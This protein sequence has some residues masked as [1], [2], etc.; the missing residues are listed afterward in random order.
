MDERS[1]I[2]PSYFPPRVCAV[3]PGWS[4]Q[5]MVHV[6]A[7][8]AVRVRRVA[9]LLRCRA[10][11]PLRLDDIVGVCV[12]F[13]RPA[14]ERIFVTRGRRLN[15]REFLVAEGVALYITLDALPDYARA[16]GIFPVIYLPYTQLLQRIG[17]WWSNWRLGLEQIV[18][19]R[20]ATHWRPA[21]DHRSNVL[22]DLWARAPVSIDGTVLLKD[23][24]EG[25]RRAHHRT[26]SEDER[27]PL[28]LWAEF[29]AAFPCDAELFE[30]G[31][32]GNDGRYHFSAS[33]IRDKLRPAAKAVWRHARLEKER[34]DDPRQEQGPLVDQL[35][36]EDSA[37]QQVIQNES[38]ARMDQIMDAVTAVAAA[39]LARAR[40]GSAERVIY[41]SFLA[42]LRGEITL[43]EL[44]RTSGMSKG[45]LSR[46]LGKAKSSLSRD[47]ARLFGDDVREAA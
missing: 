46:S 11:P 6:H 31:F 40:S 42:L 20:R 16:A 24:E 28:N 3:A 9:N 45:A 10:T 41:A 43:S 23:I 33:Q 37:V 1:T 4:L 12:L 14:C 2:V 13:A 27:S 8:D 39:R 18:S 22:S 17:G 36:G 38:T 47:L 25:I 26:L 32:L 30:L 35:V 21:P 19:A 29:R 5:P 15:S 34:L 44:S 7:A